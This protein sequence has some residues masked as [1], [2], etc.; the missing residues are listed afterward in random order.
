MSDKTKPDQPET[1]PDQ[2]ETK[3]ATTGDLVDSALNFGTDLLTMLNI[4]ASFVKSVYKVLGRFS[5]AAIEP[6]IASF[7]RKAAEIR[8]ESEA[9]VKIIEEGADQ[10]IQQ[11]EVPAEYAQVA[12]NK[13]VG[14]IIGEQ[15]NLDKIFAITVDDLKSAAPIS[16]TA[17]DTS[18]PIKDQSADS[19]NQEA[20]AS[21]E[22]TISDVWLN[23]F[24][25]EARPQSTEE[26]QLLFG[27]ILAGE[28]RNPG[29][30]SM[31]SIKTLGEFDQKIAVLFKKLCSL[32]IVSG[33]LQDPT[34]EYIIEAKVSSLGGEPGSGALSKY[35]LSFYLLNILHEYGLIIS[36]YNSQYNLFTRHIENENNSEVIPFEYQG[37]YWILR[38]LPGRDSN[39]EFN[40]PGV[41]LSKV[42]RELFRIVGQDPMSQYTEDLKKFFAD[43]MPQYTEDLK[44]F[45][46]EQNLAMIEVN[47][48]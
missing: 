16:S 34:N 5:S 15:L 24:E 26:G 41:A 10:I 21:E 44:R 23:I 47:N 7:E 33:V 2:P 42:G 4:P 48:P 28:I 43:Q 36:D 39:F 20:N 46:A 3:P 30:Y 18:E 32:C 38:P 25:T 13:Y 22:K 11:M 35:G 45:F 14:K 12:V 40:L 19:T 6:S 31:R 17:Q 37:R 9:S 29:S 27:R 1:K 8:A